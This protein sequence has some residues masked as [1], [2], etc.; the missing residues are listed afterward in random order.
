MCNERKLCIFISFYDR[1]NSIWYFSHAKSIYFLLVICHLLTNLSRLNWCYIINEVDILSTYCDWNEIIFNT[2]RREL[3]QRDN[4][5]S[6]E[7]NYLSC[8][9]ISIRYWFYGQFKRYHT[10]HTDMFFIFIFFWNLHQR[11]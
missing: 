11:Y 6:T 7:I 2:Q 3:V 9:W 5:R 1:M 10:V 4:N 8:R